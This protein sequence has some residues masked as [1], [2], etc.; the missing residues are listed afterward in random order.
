[1]FVPNFFYFKWSYDNF[2]VWALHMPKKTCK[3]TS[4]GVYVGIW[5]FCSEFLHYLYYFRTTWRQSVLNEFLPQ[6]ER[7]VGKAHT[8]KLWF[9]VSHLLR[10]YLFFLALRKKP[11]V[12]TCWK[13]VG[14]CGHFAQKWLQ[15]LKKY[16]PK[17]MSWTICGHMTI[18]LRDL[19]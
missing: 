2:L 12:L 11:D 13:C 4:I 17:S 9:L 16:E 15:K 19:C 5:H 6:L 18:L 10:Y 7:G 3:V 14:W 1:M 8:L